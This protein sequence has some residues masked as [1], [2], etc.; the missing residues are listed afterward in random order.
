MYRMVP[1]NRQAGLLGGGGGGGADVVAAGFFRPKKNIK[2]F[3]KYSICIHYQYSTTSFNPF[4]AAV[5]FWGQLGANYLEF[6][7][8]VPKTGLEFYRGK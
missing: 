6:D 4:R 7:W 2:P 5:S 1:R 3:V 8:L